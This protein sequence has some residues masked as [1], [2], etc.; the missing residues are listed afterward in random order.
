MTDDE[1]LIGAFMSGPVEPAGD[2]ELMRSG[3]RG[4]ARR[5]SFAGENALPLAVG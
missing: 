1:A 3:D 2:E 5:A 4:G